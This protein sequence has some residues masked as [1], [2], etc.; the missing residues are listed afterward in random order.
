V[1]RPI[2]HRFAVGRRRWASLGWLAGV[3][4]LL[5]AGAAGAATVTQVLRRCACP[6]D[7][8]CGSCTL[9]RCC[10]PSGLTTG[11]LTCL[12]GDEGGVPC[13]D[14]QGTRQLALAADAW[15]NVFVGSSG[16]DQAFRVTPGGCVTT[17]MDAAGADGAAFGGGR[18]LSVDAA[19]NLYMVSGAT[20][21]VFRVARDGRKSR[22]VDLQG[23]VASAVDGAGNLY[24]TTSSPDNA[25]YKIPAGS[26]EPTR[27]LGPP[28]DDVDGPRG[29]AIDKD[30]NVFVAVETNHKVFR[31]APDGTKT[32]VLD[33]NALGPDTLVQ[34]FGV[35]VDD[36]GNLYV[37]GFKTNN[38][39]K[40][41]PGGTASEILA[42]GAGH[43][44]PREIVVDAAGR[45][46]VTFQMS[47]EVVRLD[48]QP[49]GDYAAEVIIQNANDTPLKRA[50]GLAVDPAGRVFVA[51]EN[52]SNVLMWAP[53]AGT[54]GNGVLDDGEACDY[55]AP[56]TSCCCGVTCQL[57]PAQ[58][59]CNDG[60]FCT[61]VDRCTAGGACVGGDTTPCPGPDGDGDCTESCNEE[62]GDCSAPDPAATACNDGVFC[63]GTDT[64]T[65]DGECQASGIDPC[66]FGAECANTCNEDGTCFTAVGTPCSEDGNP[67]TVEL[68]D[69]HGG[70]TA[71]P[72]N[73]GLPCGLDSQCRAAPTC[74][75]LSAVCPE[76]VPLAKT[77]VLP[78]CDPNR[79]ICLDGACI[80]Q[81]DDPANCHDG[82]IDE[83][84]LCGEP[85]LP[86]GPCCTG[87]RFARQGAVCRDANG[88][89]DPAEVCNGFSADCPADSVAPP[90]TPCED[91]DPC[92]DA[93]VCA[94]G[95]CTSVQ[96]CDAQLDHKSRVAQASRLR[97]NLRLAQA[98]C[99][100]PTPEERRAAKCT[101]R[102]LVLSDNATNPGPTD[103]LSF[104]PNV[105]TPATRRRA[106]R[107]AKDNTGSEQIKLPLKL[108]P[109][110]TKAIKNSYR[111]TG[112]ARILV[113]V[114]F[115]FD[116]GS[117]ITL[118]RELALS[119]KGE[120]QKARR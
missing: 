58:T 56:G 13:A 116:D 80:C 96:I 61:A 2:H 110:A 7:T 74:D 27:L 92:T 82:T 97:A 106:K 48:P 79:S 20:N 37:T 22:V 68:C 102:G 81:P 83:G 95:T 50:R 120:K 10:K 65:A 31:V 28:A 59:V 105:V 71:V 75:G 107:F 17:I 42:A 118:T 104:S 69:G 91:G 114:D 72:G 15:G 46:Y 86:D 18:G 54:C 85:G 11:S 57:Q 53:D 40:L 108:S 4:L 111:A 98:F 45:V 14:L 33:T 26:T 12:E 43:Q 94:D 113:C 93:D 41:T 101:V 44:G 21:A 88:V 25:L 51:G 35:A 60:V 100:N 73:A 39:I 19:G 77:C 8:S 55:R 119:P 67:C 76:G 52:S 84:E 24:V 103:C 87:C 29:I 6:T 30:G 16:T 36:D 112:L 3:T 66:T 89:C 23:P 78:D 47:D 32:L 99:S 62:A 1:K 64:C 117:T 90:E 49:G 63:N 115:A 34:P 9:P 38:V 70:C 5:L 109:L